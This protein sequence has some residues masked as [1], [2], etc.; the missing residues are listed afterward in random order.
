MTACFEF[1]DLRR[2]RREQEVIR[3]R[4]R[5]RWW[6]SLQWPLESERIEEPCQLWRSPNLVSPVE[7]RSPG[8]ESGLM[9]GHQWPRLARQGADPGGPPAVG[10]TFAVSQKRQQSSCVSPDRS[11]FSETRK[12]KPK[13]LV[14]TEYGLALCAE[15]AEI[16]ERLR[17]SRQVGK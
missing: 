8:C 16:I 4:K 10:G 17:P 7:R 6:P 9:I 2:A 11:F 5:F 12:K 14:R 1:C 15:N 3:G 13:S